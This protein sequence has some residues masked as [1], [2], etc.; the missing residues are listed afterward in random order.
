MDVDRMITRP[1]LNFAV[2]QRVDE[3]RRGTESLP[4]VVHRSGDFPEPAFVSPDLEVSALDLSGLASRLRR[5][6]HAEGAAG[7]GDVSIDQDFVIRDLDARPEVPEDL[8][9]A[10][11]GFAL[12]LGGSSLAGLDE[13]FGVAGEERCEISRVVRGDETL[14]RGS[15]VRFGAQ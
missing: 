9:D 1:K 8:G 4:R 14:D 6:L 3:W 12:R 13:I 7:D 11:R 2:A 10:P 15:N 5:E